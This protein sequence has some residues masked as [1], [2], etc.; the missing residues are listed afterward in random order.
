LEWL[1]KKVQEDFFWLFADQNLSH[2][3][4]IETIHYLI[5]DNSRFPEN[6][7]KYVIGENIFAPIAEGD[8]KKEL[9]RNIEIVFPQINSLLKNNIIKPAGGEK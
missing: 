1:R 4:N 2:I 6:L 5:V 8:T 7:E 9:I 3:K